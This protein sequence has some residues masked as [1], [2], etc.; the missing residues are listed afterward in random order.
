[1]RKMTRILV[2][3]VATATLFITAAAP[4][5]A[6][7]CVNANKNQAAGVQVVINTVTNEI[8]FS[9]GVQK[10]IDQ[11]L[12]DPATG[13][14]F[15]GLIGFDLDGDGIADVS[16]FIV[17]PQDELPAQAQLNG[18]PCNGIVNIGDY[19]ACLA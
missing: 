5:M 6:H 7:E 1:M 8:W 13:I 4:A 16:S 2:S 9:D 12:I 14:G 17:T 10:R 18:A 11:G 19:F 15:H 3:G